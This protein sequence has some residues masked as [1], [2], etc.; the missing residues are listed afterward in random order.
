MK[1]Q[2]LTLTVG[3]SVFGIAFSQNTE[4]P[5]TTAV[6]FLLIHSEP[7]SSGLGEISVVCNSANQPIHFLTN[8]SLING[9]EHSFGMKFAYVPWLR[10]LVND[11]YLFDNDLYFSFNQ[12]N[13]ISYSF[14]FFKLGNIQFT[15]VQGGS[16]GEFRPKEYVI[17]LRYARLLSKK[18][19]LGVGFKYIQSNLATGQ[20]VNDVE[21]K[22]G[23]SYA[24]DLGFDYRDV[25]KISGKTFYK[26]N[27]GLAIQNLGSKITYTESEEKDFI[28]TILNL[29]LMNSFEF[30]L[31]N[32]DTA[33]VV[34][35]DI[36]YQIDK[37]MVPTPSV[38]DKDSNGIYD[39][40]EKPLMKAVF[41]SFSDAPGGATEELHE[42]IHHLGA[43]CQVIIQKKF[44][45]GFNLG[46]FFENENKG[47]RK[48]FQFA[49][50]VGLF[51]FFADF[52]YLVPFSSQRNP[53]DKTWKLSFG[54]QMKFKDRPLV[55]FF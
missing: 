55:R 32:L 24:G 28:P 46:A 6:P 51:G 18:F 2:I 14:R 17:Q 38:E 13:S 50:S 36:A 3:F 35:L 15:N 20:T 34:R 29:G 47:A 48:Y 1:K 4:I 30:H 21:I 11:I 40:R 41:Q 16:T 49:P 52:A 12:K 39:Y 37:L 27:V 43:G 31:P 22:P 23:R 44:S 42:L 25:F 54:F 26:L 5:V 8:P 7:R 53:L 33:V 45:A 10:S 9:R 19:S